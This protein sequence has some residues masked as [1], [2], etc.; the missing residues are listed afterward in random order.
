LAD[1]TDL[2]ALMAAVNH[3]VAELGRLDVNVANAGIYDAGVPTWELTK[4]RG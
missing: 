3:G 4:R 1:V 2:R